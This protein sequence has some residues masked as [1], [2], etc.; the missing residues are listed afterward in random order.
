[1]KTAAFYTLGCRTN[2]V[3]T[4]SLCALLT[5]N[6]YKRVPPYTSAKL[7]IINTCSVTNRADSKGYQLI[8][9]V[10]K[11]DPEGFVVVIGC[12]AQY[13]A[14][15]IAG[16]SGVDLVLGNVEKENI[17]KYLSQNAGKNLVSNIK[18][19][20]S[21]HYGPGCGVPDK[22][23]ASLKIQ[24]GCDNYCSYCIVPHVR[25]RS[26]SQA[27]GNILSEAQRFVALGYKE[28]VLTGI[29]IGLYSHSGC[30][31]YNLLKS[32]LD[33]PGEFRLRLSS[34][35]PDELSPGL[36]DIILNHPKSCNHLHISIQHSDTKILD[37]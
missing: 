10:I 20:K 21:V 13:N 25:G 37:N 26:R 11:A 22:S 36:M 8:R 30:D 31:L 34:I 1:M 18:K 2:Q 23:R 28:L 29:H 14:D 19:A 6:G 9:K 33:L 16:I 35:H 24:D 27:P 12:S 4:E 32:I 7:H 3:D 5:R 17:L 15:S